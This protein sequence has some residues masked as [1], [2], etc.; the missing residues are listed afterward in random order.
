MRPYRAVL[1]IEKA[2]LDDLAAFACSADCAVRIGQLRAMWPTPPQPKHLRADFAS[3]P[4]VDAMWPLLPTLEHVTT[5]CPKEFCVAEFSAAPK[6]LSLL[7]DLEYGGG[8][9]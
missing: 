8:A 5:R 6:E 9:R 4:H 1:S 2:E 3:P 7:I